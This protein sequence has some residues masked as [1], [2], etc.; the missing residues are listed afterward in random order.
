MVSK[1]SGKA[2]ERSLNLNSLASQKLATTKLNLNEKL[3]IN[4]DGSFPPSPVAKRS[5]IA[6]F[7][8]GKVEIVKSQEKIKYTPTKPP[9]Q[10][11]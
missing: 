7:E 6:K 1:Q 5:R 9:Q 8:A 10:S 2:N 3:K 4:A 11:K